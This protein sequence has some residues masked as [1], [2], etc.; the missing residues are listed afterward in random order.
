LKK[1][2]DVNARGNTSGNR[3]A[4]TPLHRAAR[5]FG[6]ERAVELLLKKGADPNVKDKNG[7]TPR[8]IAEK[9]NRTK[10]VE[11]LKKHGAK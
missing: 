3:N 8:A 6:M 11:L 5:G 9:R 4:D 1:D 2:F 10:V 7:D